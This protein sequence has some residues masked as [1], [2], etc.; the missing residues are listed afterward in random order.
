[1]ATI[2]TRSSRA[3]GSALL[4][5]PGAGARVDEV[6]GPL[7]AQVHDRL[8]LVGGDVEHLAAAGPAQ[9]LVDLFVAFAAGHGPEV[10]A[11]G[12][13]DGEP[14]S[15]PHGEFIPPP[16]RMAPAAPSGGAAAGTSRRLAPTPWPPAARRCRAA[17]CCSSATPGGAGRRPR[18]GRSAGRPSGCPWPAR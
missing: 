17:S 2:W 11:G 15:E 8:G 9:R 13:T 3:L 14:E 4:R 5:V 12:E 6:G 10:V 7:D 18:R 16:G 1:P